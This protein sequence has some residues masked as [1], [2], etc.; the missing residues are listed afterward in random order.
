MEIKKYIFEQVK[1]DDEIKKMEGEYFDSFKTIIDHDADVYIKKNGKE[2]ILFYFRKNVIPN[3]YLQSAIKSFK[4]EAKKASSV[5]GASGGKVNLDKL[6]LGIKEVINPNAFRSKVIYKDGHTSD[7]YMSNKANSMIAGYFDKEKISERHDVLKNNRLPCRTTAFTE[8]KT[9]EWANVIPLINLANNF[10]K[11]LDYEHYKLQYDTAKLTPNFQISNTAFSTITINYNWR[12]AMHLD[13]GDFH[14]GLSV[15][16]VA[17][18]GDFEGGYLGYPQY[19]VGVDVKHGD[20]LLKNPHQWHC[21]TKINGITKDWTRL[22]MILYYREKIKNCLQNSLSSSFKLNLSNI[23][24]N[25]S[26][27]TLPLTSLSPSN[28]EIITENNLKFYIRP[29][30]TDIK[31]INEVIKNH[32]YKKQLKDKIFNNNIKFDVNNG[33]LWFDLGGNIGTFTLFAMNKGAKI[34]V[35]E[36]EPDNLYLLKL[37]IKTF[38]DENKEK[39]GNVTIIPSAISSK[40][41]ILDLFLCKGDYNKYRHTL[42]KKRGRKSIKVKVLNFHDEMDKYKPNG[43]KM[44]IEGSEIDILESI[45]FEDWEK[46]KTEKLVFEYSFDIDKSIPRFLNIINNLRKYFSLVYYS[47]VKDNELIYDYFPAMTIVYCLKTL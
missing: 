23:S 2:E 38:V 4:S 31:V 45:K 8:K 1:T 35:Y 32:V 27:L 7:Y 16:M 18:E 26:S 14:N 41:G 34:I 24:K 39:T 19:D 9:K 36:P 44:D 47:K 30:T 10:Y 3:E 25:I 28:F 43:I 20:L 37:N 5:R 22:S 17:V 15:I 21:N 40:E 29:N 6:S 42:Y 11:E 33:E 46:W 13:A 12:T